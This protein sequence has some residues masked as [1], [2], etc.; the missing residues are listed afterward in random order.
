MPCFDQDID[1]S[2]HT[3]LSYLGYCCSFNY[4]RKNRTTSPL[5]AH[6][7]GSGGGISLIGT[8]GPQLA[9]GKSGI[10]FSA[11]FMLFVHHPFDYPVEASQMT[12]FG[13]GYETSVSVYPTV[14]LCTDEVLALSEE[15]RNCISASDVGLNFYRQSDCSLACLRSTVYDNC[16]CH[17]YYLPRSK[18]DD[19]RYQD[20]RVIDA[21]CFDKNFCEY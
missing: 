19:G 5:K 10:I 18:N 3:S 2:W 13:V 11:G 1:F 8:G 17:P 15:G 6:T 4:F 16:G 7:F 14:T 21:E 12:F 20:C 9:D